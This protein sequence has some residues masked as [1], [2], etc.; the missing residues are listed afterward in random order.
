MKMRKISARPQLFRQSLV[1]AH[2]DLFISVAVA[3]EFGRLQIRTVINATAQAYENAHYFLKLGEPVKAIGR[4]H[5]AGSTAPL[6]FI[7]P[8]LFLLAREIEIA[9][10]SSWKK[11]PEYEPLV[12]KYLAAVSGKRLGQQHPLTH[13]LACFGQAAAISTFYPTLWSCII[14]HIDQLADGQVSQSESQQIR[15]KA[16]FY[17]VRVLRNNR[18]YFAAVERCKEL[19]QLCITVD[20]MRSFS[21]NRARYNLAVD[22]CEAGNMDN[23]MEAYEEAEKYLRRINSSNDGWIFAIFATSERA[24]RYE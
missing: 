21:A 15:I 6:L 4:F 13:L 18:D 3:N 20:G 14:D 1:S 19:I 17:L 16:Y 5:D 7:E 9:T 8:D 24:Q 11:F 23:A 10:W 2:L 12:F 22:H